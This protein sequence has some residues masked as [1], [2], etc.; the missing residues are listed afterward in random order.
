MMTA[1]T[2]V[3]CS[4]STPAPSPTASASPSA[5][6]FE[7]YTDTQER[8]DYQ[9]ALNTSPN[10]IASNVPVIKDGRLYL[11]ERKGTERKFEQ[12]CTGRCATAVKVNG[13]YEV[14][15]PVGFTHQKDDYQLT[16]PKDYVSVPVVKLTYWGP[17]THKPVTI[18][19][20]T[21]A[22]V[23]FPETLNHRKLSDMKDGDEGF[24]NDDDIFDTDKGLRIL[25]YAEVPREP[26]TPL[27]DGNNTYTVPV[28]KDRGK[29][30]VC[31]P[32][33][34]APAHYS[35]NP[36]YVTHTVLAST[37]STC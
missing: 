3:A 28:F 1:A 4:T 6:A 27:Y 5:P 15:L 31:T 13:G 29:I 35:N 19:S 2:L 34:W 18:R 36:V 32:A 37:I 25:D 20:S 17:D 24:V 7:A 33:T 12:E 16:D 26:N 22:S 10:R 9:T 23:S 30:V 21:P 8:R 14:S 11:A